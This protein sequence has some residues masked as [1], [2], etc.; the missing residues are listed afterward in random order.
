M[1]LGE[2]HIAKGRH[3]WYNVDNHVSE[4]E[5][6]MAE[7]DDEFMDDPDGNIDGKLSEEE[8]D[9]LSDEEADRLLMQDMFLKYLEGYKEDPSEKKFEN[10]FYLQIKLG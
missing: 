3:P 1:F 9:E 5:H 2:G 10:L 6:A 4:G 7:L 8:F